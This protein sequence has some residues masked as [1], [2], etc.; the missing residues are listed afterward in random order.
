MYAV[1][2]MISCFAPSN[3]SHDPWKLILFWKL[4]SALSSHFHQ[5]KILQV[6]RNLDIFFRGGICQCRQWRRQ[7]KIFASG[8]N[9]SIYTHFLCFFLPKLLKLGEIYGVK[10][11]AGK[12][13]GVNFLTNSMSDLLLFGCYYFLHVEDVHCPDLPN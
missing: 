4:S 7:C 2:N 8:V 11:L 1:C 6:T 3:F 13:V 9:F 10:F 5:L 12:S